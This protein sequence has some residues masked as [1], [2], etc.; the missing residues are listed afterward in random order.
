MGFIQ[1]FKG[2]ISG[3]LADQWKDYYIP[4]ENIPGTA[5]IFEQF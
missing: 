3:T 1:A 2:T 4:M 5:A